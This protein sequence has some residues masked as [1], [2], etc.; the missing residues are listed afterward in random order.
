MRACVLMTMM[1]MM[2]V[3]MMNTALQHF[4]WFCV[5][6]STTA[7]LISC[8]ASRY[9]LRRVVFADNFSFTSIWVL[10]PVY[11]I[12]VLHCSET[13]PR[14][15]GSVFA[16][17][18]WVGPGVISCCLSCRRILLI[19]CV[20]GNG[21]LLRFSFLAWR[22]ATGAVNAIFDYT[23]ISWCGVAIVL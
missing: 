15:H 1:L 13:S 2:M 20:A 11:V 17:S 18:P 12:V 23:R 8:H 3:M 6:W 9:I 21:Q 10:E 7:H 4:R 16:V 5:L 22:S 19:L 14:R